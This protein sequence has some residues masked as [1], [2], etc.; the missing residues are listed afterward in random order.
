MRSV[1]LHQIWS[2][3]HDC[4][5]GARVGRAGCAR[6]TLAGAVRGEPPTSILAFFC[7]PN[8]IGPLH[9]RRQA[10]LQPRRGKLRYWRGKSTSES[11]AAAPARRDGCC[12][13]SEK[14]L[15]SAHAAAERV[16][17]IVI[18][19]EPR[20]SRGDDLG[21]AA[22]DRRSGHSRPRS[23]SRARSP[24]PAGFTTAKPPIPGRLA[25]RSAFVPCTRRRVRVGRSRA[26]STMSIAPVPARDEHDRRCASSRCASG[27]RCGSCASRWDSGAR[28]ACSCGLGA[29]V[30]RE[31]GR[32]TFRRTRLRG[33][34]AGTRTAEA[35]NGLQRLLMCAVTVC[36][37]PPSGEVPIA[38]SPGPNG[39]LTAVA[40]G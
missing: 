3:T 39:R 7:K 19:A 35:T 27:T 21:H 31:L 17:P 16:D 2:G 9:C 13:A 30:V 8:P 29:D 36:M 1:R 40:L 33:A 4:G 32:P 11:I 26:G 23:S 15:L 22:R 12:A 24:W 38:L 6:H 10:A 14:G 34:R 18:D 5:D 37:P 28:P 25:Q 20:D